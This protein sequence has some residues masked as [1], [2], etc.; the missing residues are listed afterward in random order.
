MFGYQR[1]A[2]DCTACLTERHEWIE[3]GL[4]WPTVGAASSRMADDLRRMT[5]SDSMEVIRVVEMRASALPPHGEDKT[6]GGQ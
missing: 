2:D 1:G 6:P 3:W 5:G 4:L